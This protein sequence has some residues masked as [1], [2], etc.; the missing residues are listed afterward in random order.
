MP[1]E[2]AAAPAAPVSIVAKQNG[3]AVIQI[4]NPP[5]NSLHPRVQEGI[6]K[7][8]REACADPEVK[9]VVITGNKAFFMAG[10]DIEYVHSM[11]NKKDANLN[12]IHDFVK[13][14][15]EIF[16]NL[17]S[18]PKPIVAAV[19][20]T[21]LGGGCEL[22]MACAAR[23]CLPH[24]VFGQPE[25]KL[26][27]IPGLGGT[28]RFPRLIGL[29]KGVQYT[30]SGK[31][32]KANEAL[33]LGLVD[34]LV[35]KPE[36]LLLTAGKLALDIAS[37][38]VPRRKALYEN[39]KIGSYAIGKAVI[40]T[41]RAQALTKTP[42]IPHPFAYL[43]AVEEGLKNGPDAGLKKE[44]QLMAELVM[45]PSAKA[46]MHFF[47]ASRATSKVKGVPEKPKGKPIQNVCVIG[48]GTMGAG[49]C[50]VYLLKGYNVILKEI[51]DKAAEAGVA[52]IIDQ[53]TR[54]MKARRLP[55]YGIETVMR[56][57]TVQTSYDN[58]DKLDL[59]I[60]AVL[61]NLKL[62]QDIFA[63][64][65]KRCPKHC[66]L[67]T[68]TSTIDIEQIGSKTNCQDRICGLHYFSPAHI[69]PLLEIIKS[70][71][72]STETLSLVLQV[73]KRTGKTP[74]V[75]GNCTGFAANRAFFPYGMAAG[76][77]VDN[78]VSPYKVDKALEKFGMPMGVFRMSDLSGND[79]GQYVK[80]IIGASYGD[81]IYDSPVGKAV[82]ESGRLGQKTGVGWYKYVKGKHTADA[83]LD[84]LLA[85]GRAQ[86]KDKV[87]VDLSKLTEDEIVEVCLFPVVNESLRIV[88]EGMVQSAGDLDVVTITGYGYP[89]WRGGM[90]HWGANHAKGGFKYINE[91]LEHYSKTF[92]A[93]S[94]A[95]QR[96]F[97]PC[98]LLQE[99]AKAQ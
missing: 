41:A 12:D 35:K 7:C 72:T 24:S 91:R 37:G 50:I 62:K 87:A 38:K 53:L 79:V 60:E 19:N 98:Q 77:L 29:Q 30:M 71:H 94:E 32:I 58:F 49:I 55:L 93:N 45:S 64:L 20:G 52:R 73:A 47:F 39:S 51:N 76:L 40:E 25:L 48:G 66:I 23:V 15:N 14:G 43:D 90:L 6:D 28:Q 95:I 1:N 99:K 89:A 33:K 59:V 13:K 17:E 80:G 42:S 70:K 5:V 8:Y 22:A 18:G 16:N 36:E 63:E 54:V 68:N 67:A 4:N 75:V 31:Q 86:V 44:M 85:K 84:A 46:L 56:N 69:M 92:G 3:V 81:R 78:G 97:K 61:E 83:S 11:Q 96:F 88:A 65:E 27:I 10:A 74:V 2:V 26:G 57:L 21:A 34:V 9:A 82:F